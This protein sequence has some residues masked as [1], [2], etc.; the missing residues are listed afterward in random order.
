MESL[1]YR[2]ISNF[3]KALSHPTRLIIAMELLEGKRCVNDIRELVKVR[4]PNISQHLSILKAS[5]VV[6]W[7]QQGRMKCYF[8][9]NPQL[10][11]DILK[12]IKN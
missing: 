12:A 3:F 7:I 6:D 11:R 1:D 2:K 4:Q 8:L 10:I 9:K 5:G